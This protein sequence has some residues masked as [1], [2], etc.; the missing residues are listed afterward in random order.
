[1]VRAEESRHLAFD[2]MLPSWDVASIQQA[3]TDPLSILHHG[4]PP[5]WTLNN[6]DVQRIVTR[7]GRADVT[8]P[9]GWSNNV[10]AIAVTGDGALWLVSD[11]A[12][13]GIIDDDL[14]PPAES[15]T[16]LLRIP[17]TAAARE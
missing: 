3:V 11:N 9:E 16:L 14:P 7:L 1:M 8:D 2:L 15:R 12:V 4:V 5:A 17:P 6:H 10:E 13:T